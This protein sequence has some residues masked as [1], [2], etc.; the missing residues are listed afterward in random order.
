MRWQK[1][2]NEEEG[3]GPRDP[4]QRCAGQEQARANDREQQQFEARLFWTEGAGS[5]DEGG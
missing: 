5:G 3:L 2:Q 1:G 4:S